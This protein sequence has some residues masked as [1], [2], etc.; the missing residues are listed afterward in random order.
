[1]KIEKF[2]EN[3]IPHVRGD[4]Y[5]T[6]KAVLYKI[7]ELIDAINYLKGFADLKQE[8]EPEILPCPFCGGP[9]E[10][11]E[12]RLPDRDDPIPFEIKCTNGKCRMGIAT[13]WSKT[14]EDALEIW[15]RRA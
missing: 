9:G 14:F 1:M 15:N 12:W 6:F 3:L 10:L 11:K 5:S 8:K 4:G 2:D 7:N 13:P